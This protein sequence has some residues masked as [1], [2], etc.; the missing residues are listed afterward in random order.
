MSFTRRKWRL[1]EVMQTWPSN[2]AARLDVVYVETTGTHSATYLYTNKFIDINVIYSNSTNLKTAGKFEPQLF[3]DS[4]D[5]TL[6]SY[7]GDVLIP[8]LNIT[9]IS[10]PEHEQP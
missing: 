7:F 3:K 6:T 9:P 1:S 2:D 10:N 8:D 5:A 4:I